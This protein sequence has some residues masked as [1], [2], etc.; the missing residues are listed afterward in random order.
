MRIEV[1]IYISTYVSMSMVLHHDV[2]YDMN[3]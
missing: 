2:R 3:S 1:N